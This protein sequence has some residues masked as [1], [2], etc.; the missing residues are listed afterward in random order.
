[1]MHIMN[2]IH[3]HTAL[4]CTSVIV[5]K[6]YMNTRICDSHIFRFVRTIH[7]DV[8]VASSLKPSNN[9]MCEEIKIMRSIRV[10]DVA[11]DCV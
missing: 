4:K 1:M 3:F 11:L 2:D 8:F 10:F 7:S 6:N 5:M 9:A